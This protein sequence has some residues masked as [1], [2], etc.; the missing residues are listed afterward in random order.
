VNHTI[1]P[2][3]SNV[4]N[5]QRIAFLLLAMSVVLSIAAPGCNSSPSPA[6]PT[7]SLNSDC[8]PPITICAIGRC[9]PQCVT[10]ADCQGGTCVFGTDNAG[11]KGFFCQ[12]AADAMK[13]CSTASDCTPPLACASDYRCR[14]LC[15][16]DADCNVA[17]ATN[18][19]CAQD[20]NKV[21]Y[22]ANKDEVSVNAN[23]DQVISVAP[24]PAAMTDAAVT[25]PVDAPM[26]AIV[27]PE[28]GVSGSSG[29][30][31][32][33]SSG[34]ASGASTGSTSDA[35]STGS[36]SAGSSSGSAA[37]P[38]A[39][40]PEAAPPAEAGP[41]EAGLSC[42]TCAVGTACNTTIGMCQT[43]GGVGAPCCP[44]TACG[45]NLVCGATN[46]CE[47]GNANEP[48]CGG[49]G[50]TCNDN[51]TCQVSDAGLPSSCVCGQ[52][53][54]ACCPA[55]PAGAAATC[56]GQG[57]C[58]GRNCGCAVEFEAVSG[59]EGVVRLV[60]GTLRKVYDEDLD[61]TQDDHYEPVVSAAGPLRVAT[62][63]GKLAVSG[64]FA[65]SGAIGCAI[66]TDGSVWCFP[67][68][69]TLADS[70]YIGNGGG[71]TVAVSLAQQVWSSVD[72]STKLSGAVQIAGGTTEY[73]DFCAV[74]TG[75]SVWCWG[76]NGSGQLGTGDTGTLLY[77]SQVKSTAGALAA[78]FA[79]AAEVTVS[80]DSACARKTADGSV[81]C[82]GNN[83]YA[84]LGVPAST[85]FTQNANYYPNKVT[86][87]GTTTAT[88]LIVG[89]EDTFCAI[90]TDTSVT[91]WGYNAYG[92]SG[93]TPT[94]NPNAP[95]TT[96]LQTAGGMALTGVTDVLGDASGTICARLST[97]N[98]PIFCWGGYAASTPY[99]IA[100][101]DSTNVAVTG[102]TGPIFGGYYSS[103]CYVDR[104]A[105]VS[106]GGNP[107]IPQP[108]CSGF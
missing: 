86:I 6:E 43:C 63:A 41:N 9:R 51:I 95:P 16:D 67:L 108:D 99:P 3:G 80:Y 88:K 59:A 55:A 25:E 23:N 2:L 83:N 24:N 36:G 17:G 65:G 97:A 93:L 68:R 33:S 15:T 47:C 61:S 44:G 56:L 19:V 78:P 39:S 8:H 14:N 79:G 94:G 92:Q 40:M 105:M 62:G 35:A 31:S 60:D 81:W 84:Q 29:A 32:G 106:Y 64:I 34:S 54:T 27:A 38:D 49:N 10:D 71:P 72:G 66:V 69:D 101:K 1:G 96:V 100:F 75:G 18:K 85:L 11:S 42:G 107:Q 103:L 77:A 102:I 87:L 26:I 37:M 91:C 89:P 5:W 74:D 7:C 98:T 52:I 50:G 90:M 12:A 4:R 28:G 82:W 53:G 58:A 46:L 73:P 30:S 104:N 22:C 20:A 13:A 45:P 70:T 76:Y 21:D 57:V 48:C